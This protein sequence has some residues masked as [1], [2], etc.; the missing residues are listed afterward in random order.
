[1]ALRRLP[2]DTSFLFVLFYFASVLIPL[3]WPEAE[4]NFCSAARHDRQALTPGLNWPLCSF[5]MLVRHIGAF[6]RRAFVA[7]IDANGC[8]MCLSSGE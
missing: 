4:L 8:D 5:L 7:P 2:G 1:M 3:L 6:L